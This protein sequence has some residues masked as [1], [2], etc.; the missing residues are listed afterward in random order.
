MVVIF[1]EAGREPCFFFC[2]ELHIHSFQIQKIPLIGLTTIHKKLSHCQAR[3]RLTGRK[4][5]LQW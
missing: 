4:P 3:S 5:A 1:I 2:F